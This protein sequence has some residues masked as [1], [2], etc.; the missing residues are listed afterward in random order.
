MKFMFW[1]ARNGGLLEALYCLITVLTSF[2]AKRIVAALA[3]K[4]ILGME[5]I[6][7]EFNLSMKKFQAYQVQGEKGETAISMEKMDADTLALFNETMTQFRERVM[8]EM[9]KPSIDLP[10]SIANGLKLSPLAFTM[11]EKHV[12]VNLIAD[13]E[14]MLLRTTITELEKKV[15]SLSQKET[16]IKQALK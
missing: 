11:L 5:P 9:E 7:K 6:E 15:A 3:D 8:F 14:N 12:T 1:D 2:R 13:D 16:A 10:E 4:V